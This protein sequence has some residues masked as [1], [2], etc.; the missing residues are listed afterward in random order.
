[1]IDVIIFNFNYIDYLIGEDKID[2]F[3]VFYKY[4][5]K[6]WWCLRKIFIEFKWKSFFCSLGS[7]LFIVIGIFV[8]G[9][10]MNLILFFVL[11]GIGFFLKI[12]IDVK[13][14]DRKID[15]CKFIFIIYEKILIELRFY[16]RGR[17]FDIFLFFNEVKFIDDIIIDLC[18][19]F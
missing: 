1:M 18:L 19:I 3:K 11:I 7:I 10:I 5:Y 12:Y 13:K 17:L 15:M 14:F 16:L 8:G 6:K 2:E 4:Y 9:L